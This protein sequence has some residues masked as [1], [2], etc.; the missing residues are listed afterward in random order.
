MVVFPE[1]QMQIFTLTE[2]SLEVSSKLQVFRNFNKFTKERR[3][4]ILSYCKCHHFLC[5]D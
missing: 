4:N 2:Q 3:A 1:V 5:I